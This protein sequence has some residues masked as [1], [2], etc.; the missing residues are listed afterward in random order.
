MCT[1]FIK[2]LI[3]LLSLGAGSHC[4]LNLFL[5]NTHNKKKTQKKLSNR[6]NL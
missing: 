1:Y 6:W 3:E 5:V 4:L 2:L